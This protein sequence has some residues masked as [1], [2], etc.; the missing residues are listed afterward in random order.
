MSAVLDVSNNAAAVRPNATMADAFERFRYDVMQGLAQQVKS[1]PCTWLYDQR[2]SQLFEAITQLDEYYPARNETLILERC[3]GQIAS[4]AGP[5][6][7]RGARPGGCGPTARLPRTG[8]GRYRG[9]GL[10]AAIS[11]LEWVSS[12]EEYGRNR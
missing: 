7:M 12:H 11:S 9:R 6:W 8:S 3:A 10:A 2:G 4:A 1:I 5:R